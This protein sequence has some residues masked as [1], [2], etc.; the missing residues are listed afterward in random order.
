MRTAVKRAMIAVIGDGHLPES[1]RR[2]H[3]AYECGKLL[4]DRGFRIVTGG[5]GGVMR[6][7]SWGATSSAHYQPGDVIGVLP[8]HNPEDANEYVDIVVATGFDV[9][10]NLVVANADA[11][12]A[13]GGGAGTLSEIAIAWQLHRLI[14]G[15]RVDGWSGE[16]ADRR[17]D[18]R[19]RYPDIVDDRVY[20]ADGPEDAVRHIWERLPLYQRRHR[21]VRG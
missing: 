19:I 5:L 3:L 13:I 8:G 17:V 7:A 16:L 9:A 12:I 20:G 14:V 21:G 1:D 15:L 4:V 10:R 6:A 2:I 18:A 11:V